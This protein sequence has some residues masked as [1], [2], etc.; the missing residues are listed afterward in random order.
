MTTGARTEPTLR[1]ARV[2]GA[3]RALRA[4]AVLATA[5]LAAAAATVPAQA[6]PAGTASLWD[7]TVRISTGPDGAQP[8]GGTRP[9]GLSAGG[10]WAVIDSDATNLVPGDTNGL[11]DVFVRDQLTGRTERVSL[12][13]AGGQADGYS[14]DGV[15]DALGRNVVFTSS[16]ALVPEDTNGVEDVYLRDRWT[17]RTERISVGD[18]AREVPERYSS[19]PSISADGRYVAFASSRSDLVPDGTPYDRYNVYVTDRLRGTT[20]LITIGADGSPANRPSF[21][22]VISE[23][24]RTVSFTSRATNLL[25][26]AEGGGAGESAEDAAEDAVVPVSGRSA[27]RTAAVLPSGRSTDADAGIA[28]PRLYPFYVHDL[29][30]GRTTGAS[31]DETGALRGV[32]SGTVSPDGRLAVY[33]YL[34]PTGEPGGGWRP[35]LELFVRDLRAGTVRR[36]PIE[37]PGTLTTGHSYEPVIAPGNRWVYFT[38]SAHNLVEGDTNSA[39]DVF[40]HD[41]LTGRTE[42]VSV[43]ADGAESAGSSYGAVVGGL[44][45]TVLFSSEDGTLVAGD[46]NG[47]TDAFSRRVLLF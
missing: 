14:F 24:G 41:L 26:P 17:G 18:P 11:T 3:A 31:L 33:S 20:R 5:V 8:D 44:G 35:H 45:T 15:I 22:P 47:W 21:S 4:A 34:V 42:R 2:P 23:D 30:T 46:T 40:R 36:L 38:S 19:D 9:T 1:T 39:E 10:R 7:R 29:G 27:R 25:P 43:A 37:R 28:K 12:T 6:G 16:A 13:A 32:N